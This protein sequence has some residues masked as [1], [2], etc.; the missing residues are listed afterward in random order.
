MPTEL[1]PERPRR[2]ILIDRRALAEEQRQRW[3]IDRGFIAGKR[4]QPRDR[5]L[6]GS[7]FQGYCRP[8]WV[9]MARRAA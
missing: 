3:L 5:K 6:R 7:P 8:G 4:R 1:K 2:T 9:S